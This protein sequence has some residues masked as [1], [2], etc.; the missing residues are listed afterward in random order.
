MAIDTPNIS[1]RIKIIIKLFLTHIL[2]FNKIVTFFKMTNFFA[3]K[4]EIN[5]IFRQNND[6]FSV[7]S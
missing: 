4:Y 2:F 3:K 6:G 7:E 5:K 1:R